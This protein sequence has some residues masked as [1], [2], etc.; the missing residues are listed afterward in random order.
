MKFPACAGL[1]SL[2][3]ASVTM[4]VQGA[5]TETNPP[6]PLHSPPGDLLFVMLRLIGGLFLVIAVFLGVVWFFKKSSFFRLYH[7]APA[8]LKIL[9][10]RSLGYRNTLFVIAYCQHRFL[11]SVSAT[12]ASLLASLPDAPASESGGPEPQTFADHLGA[13]HKPKA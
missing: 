4:G 10:S 5:L 13:L 1:L 7:G 3:L 11:V 9:E 12:G 8:Q 2:L 6:S